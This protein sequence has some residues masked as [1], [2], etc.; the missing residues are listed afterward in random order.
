MRTCCAGVVKDVAPCHPLQCRFR[1]MVYVEVH[2][3]EE[4]AA[5]AEEHLVV[6]V[7][8]AASASASAAAVAVV[9]WLSAEKTVSG[10][11]V[12]YHS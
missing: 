8:A 6:L 2:L 3:P 4:V 10:L 12:V 1:R 5:T 11:D 9:L 7:D